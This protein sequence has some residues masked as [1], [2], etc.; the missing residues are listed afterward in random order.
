MENLRVKL[1][2]DGAVIEEMVDAYERG[3]IKGFTTNPS[4]MKKAGITEY[5]TFAKQAINKIPDMPISFEVFSDDFEI[6]EKEAEKIASWG[7]NVYVKIPISNSIGE[8]SLPLIQSLSEKGISLNVTAILTMEQVRE[9][10]AAFAE[11]TNNIV[12][13]FAGRIADSGI[14]PIPLMKEAAQVCKQKKGTELLWASSR[15]LLNIFQAEECECDIITCTQEI[16][17]KLPNV[18]KSLE[19]ISLET[20]QM[21]SKDSK[22]LGFSII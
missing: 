14:D 7:E 21:F 3:T 16:L 10:V 6:M 5:E 9:T 18:G 1:Y 22:E 15:E 4:L 12:S 19:Q 2:A 13:V 20:V 8:S 11:G 17:N